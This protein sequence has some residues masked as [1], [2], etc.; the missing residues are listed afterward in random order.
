L[1]AAE[2][3]LHSGAG[4]ADLERNVRDAVRCHFNENERRQLAR[5]YFAVEEVIAV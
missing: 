5:L 3:R 1:A 4:V 2:H